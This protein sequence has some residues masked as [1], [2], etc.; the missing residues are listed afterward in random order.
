VK[1]VHLGSRDYGYHLPNGSNPTAPA[2]VVLV[3]HA[4]GIDADAMEEATGL[5]D[6]AD[7]NGFVAVYPNGTLRPSPIPDLFP[8]LASIRYWSAGGIFTIPEV[9]D[10]A[11]LAG[12]LEDLPKH[13]NVDTNRVYV[14][15][16]SNGAMMAYRLAARLSDKVR[17][18]AAVGGVI[19]SAD[20]KPTAGHMSVLHVHG[21]DDPIVKF[22]G[23]V[24]HQSVENSVLMC[25][26][27]NQCGAVSKG[28][29]LPSSGPLSV[30]KWDYGTGTS[31]GKVILYVVNK[32]GHTWPSQR[33]TAR[34][35]PSL[36]SRLG[37]ISTNL[38]T[39]AVIW[40][41]FN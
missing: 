26:Q 19:L 12:V 7:Q 23:G 13:A 31:G 41:F 5:S 24:W 17:A 34:I 29:P 39:N 21:T 18:V 3:L 8:G 28:P 30:E 14:A 20:W 36:L 22:G 11:F 27:F 38:D 16:M 40:S 15:G 33:L 10:V 35:P 25:A 32:G 6:S 2:P 4:L 9:D 1:K 37:N